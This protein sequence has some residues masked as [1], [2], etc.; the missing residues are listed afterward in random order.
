MSL[1]GAHMSAAGGPDAAVRRAAEIGAE[2]MQ[3]FTQNP[4]QWKGRAISD[5]QADAFRRELMKSG[6]RRVISH[7]PY[8]LNLAADGRIASMSASV[9]CDEIA[10]CD[11]LG[12]D[13]IVLHPGSAIDSPRAEALERLAGNLRGV[14]SSTRGSPVK[15]LLETMAGGGGV[16][17]ATVGE[18]A[19]VIEMLEW[20]DRLGVCVDTC[21]VFAAGT[22]IRTPAGYE[23]SVTS[24]KSQVGLSRVGC[25]HLSDSRGALGSKV[26]RHAH[27]GDGEIGTALFGALVSDE[28]FRD[29]PMILETPKDGPGDEGNIALLRK[30]RGCERIDQR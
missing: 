8:L 23:R 4:R 26:D 28:R 6:V 14:L 9:L 7:A 2:S 3:L 13:A 20:D 12:V 1:I 29:V 25:W 18:L 24:L 19:D 27:I 16:L 11:L 17:G 15:I 5:T 30:M 21:H 10:R 22:D